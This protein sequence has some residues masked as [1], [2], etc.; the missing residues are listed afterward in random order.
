MLKNGEGLYTVESE[1][2]SDGIEQNKH[3]NFLSV[4]V[5]YML[6]YTIGKVFLSSI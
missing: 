3:S 5:I 1:G 4:Y 2:N 6:L